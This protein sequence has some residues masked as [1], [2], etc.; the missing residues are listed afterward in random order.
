MPELRRIGIWMATV[1]LLSACS[2]PATDPDGGGDPDAGVVDGGGEPDAGAPD[3]GGGGVGGDPSAVC[4]PPTLDGRLEGGT[5]D[6]R[7]T[8]PGLLAYD[9]YIP[10]VHALAR[11]ADGSLLVAGYFLWVGQ[12]PVRSLARLRTDGTWEEVRSDLPSD[13]AMISAVAPGPGGEL[14][15]ASYVPITIGASPFPQV[16]RIFV[17]TGAGLREIG[18][19]QGVVRAMAWVDGRLWVGGHFLLDETM[20]IGGLVVW[21]EGEGWSEPPGGPVDGPVYALL[22]TDE[23]VTV[24]GSFTTIGGIPARAVAEWDGSSWTALSMEGFDPAEPYGAYAAGVIVFG[25]ARDDDGTLYA[26]GSFAPP[27]SVGGSVARWT[28]S[29]WEIVGSGLIDHSEYSGDA[30]GVVADIAFHDG[31]L[32]ATGC[33]DGTPDAPDTLPQVAR[34]DGT[35]WEA[36]PG[37]RQPAHAIGPWAWGWQVCGA[38]PSGTAILEALHQRVFSHDGLLYVG[39]QFVEVGGTVSTSLIAYDGRRWI[40]LGDTNGLG[41]ADAPTDVA[42][43]DPECGVYTLKPPAGLASPVEAVYRFDGETWRALPIPLPTNR[44][45]HIAVSAA[46][47]VF[48]GCTTHWGGVGEPEEPEPRVYRYEGEWYDSE[49]WVYLGDIPGVEQ[50][51]VNDIAIDPAGRL[52]IV[53]GQITGFVAMYDGERLTTFEDGFDGLVARIAFDRSGSGAFVVGGNFTHV[54][55][56]EAAGIARWDGTAWQPVGEGFDTPPSAL[57]YDGDVI[58]AS[59]TPGDP[60]NG[61]VQY[62]LARWDGTQWEELATP[63]RGLLP[64]KDAETIGMT[65]QVEA[66][67]VKGDT[68]VIAGMIDPV[69]SDVRAG[70]RNVFV[71]DGER[72]QALAGGVGAQTVLSIA[73]TPN[74]LWF[75]GYIATTGG[76]DELAPSVGVAHFRFAP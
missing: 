69:G 12:Q 16:G 29:N 18:S 26:G 27:G 30:P 25:L 42:V 48:I 60:T 11:D 24:G 19:F 50:G 71:F 68:I 57:A 61:D 1:A 58:Y 66:I 35:R 22:V 33:V 43:G 53:G 47:D 45:E 31:Y 55:S 37:T 65:H 73:A 64:H 59:T 40:A 36:P 9:G 13:V 72:F 8:I 6:S 2:D 34:W 44:C 15:F 38:E 4:D 20:P 52:W 41:V 74:G 56:V 76:H 7:L 54:G 23:S 67:W 62:V 46:G 63:E 17:D 5:W 32:F 3:A 75:G 21:S 51:M 10:G 28:G 14:A 70:G 39:G 49:G